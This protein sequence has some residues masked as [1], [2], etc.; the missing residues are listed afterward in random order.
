MLQVKVS[1]NNN[2]NKKAILIST[3]LFSDPLSQ[4][5]T[6]EARWLC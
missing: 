5:G 6:V 2:V 1:Q 3:Q 4:P